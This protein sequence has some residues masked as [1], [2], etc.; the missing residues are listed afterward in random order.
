MPESV[1]DPN[2]FYDEQFIEELRKSVKGEDMGGLV[3]LLM[4]VHLYVQNP[5]EDFADLDEEV[6][7]QNLAIFRFLEQY[8]LP[9][10]IGYDRDP[11]KI[12]TDLE[13]ISILKEKASDL[14]FM[15]S[16]YTKIGFEFPDDEPNNTEG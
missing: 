7:A 8:L 4:G 5:N 15:K 6:T 13:T 9:E 14:A 1:E 16:I 2:E 12:S 3:Q 10:I 11:R